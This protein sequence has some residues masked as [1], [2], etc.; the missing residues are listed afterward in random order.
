MPILEVLPGLITSFLNYKGREQNKIS[1]K[2][3]L[4]VHARLKK[5]NHQKSINNLSLPMVLLFMI[6]IFIVSIVVFDIIGVIVITLKDLLLLTKKSM[7]FLAYPIWFVA[8]VFN[9]LCYTSFA[10]DLVKKNITLAS[11]TWLIVVMATVLSA[12]AICIFNYYG[13]MN[14]VKYDYYVPGNSGLTYTFFIMLILS[15]F[16]FVNMKNWKINKYKK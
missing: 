10:F 12:I 13:Q 8:A 7:I 15:T 1:K 14:N 2:N 16:F 11:N 5:L 6:A 3:I 9:G 4:L